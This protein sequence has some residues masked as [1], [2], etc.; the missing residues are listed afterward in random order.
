MDAR[1]AG[2]RTDMITAPQADMMR[3]SPTSLFAVVPY[4]TISLLIG[5]ALAALLFI[6]FPQW[7]LAFSGLFYDP[8]SGFFLSDNPLVQFSYR[9]NRYIAITGALWL[10]A[11]LTTTTIKKNRLFGL[12]K[13]AYAYLLVVALLG[14]GLVVNTVFKNQ[15]GRARPDHVQQFGGSDHFTPALVMSDQCERNCS[16]VSGHASVFFYFVAL[17]LLY[18]GRRRW[19]IMTGAVTLGALTGL[20]RIVQGGHFLSDVVFSFLFVALTA[21]VVHRFVYGPGAAR[22]PPASG[23]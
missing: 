8:Q 22:E 18:R 12:D 10:L 13:K 15:W 16:F 2:R 3:A 9:A 4:F 21:V 14:P 6:L 1:P 11:G 19:L 23:R 17:G 5:F 20:G 7:D